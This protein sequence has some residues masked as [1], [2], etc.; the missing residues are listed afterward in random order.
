M[1]PVM[2]IN[3]IQA[4]GMSPMY[5]IRIDLVP[6]NMTPQQVAQAQIN[7][8][9]SAVQVKSPVI[10]NV[11]QTA[12][13][14]PKPANV[15]KEDVGSTDKS[16]EKQI[17]K[18][19]AAEKQVEDKKQETTVSQA[20]AAQALVPTSPALQVKAAEVAP[21]DEA[22]TEPKKVVNKKP[23]IVAPELMKT[24]IDINGLVAIL[25]SPD[26]EEQADAMEAIAQVAKYA[27]DR[28]GELFDKKV[29][30]S[31]QEIANRDTS[32]LDEKNKVLADRNKEYAMFT[33]ATLQK[34][35][36]DEVKNV[37]DTTVPMKDLVGMKS[38]MNGLNNENASI[39]EAAVA[40]LGYIKKPEYNSELNA[41]LKHAKND[42]AANVKAQ[43]DKHLQ[44]I[45]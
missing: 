34:L 32:E 3:P 44:E 29:I 6:V 43:A 8:E 23:E 35:Y 27:P 40:A 12:V 22:K 45:A 17:E 9:Q 4:Y 33:T 18:K 15:I 36:S 10:Y 39:R 26:Y 24:S 1:Y 28:A 13:Y 30:D 5:S 41:L 42:S 38:I 19:Q 31:L 11:P 37:T 25:S 2:M 7:G 21:K 14:G 20:L 16:A